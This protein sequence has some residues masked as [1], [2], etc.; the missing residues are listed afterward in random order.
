MPSLITAGVLA[1]LF[2]L[3]FWLASAPLFD[4]SLL[5]APIHAVGLSA[6]LCGIGVAV[7]LLSLSRHR[8]LQRLR[9]AHAEL[10]QYQF[11]ANSLTDMLSVMDCHY[12]Y[13]AVN[14]AYCRMTGSPR[15]GILGRT[16]SQMWGADTFGRYI[17]PHVKRCLDGETVS[18]SAWMGFQDGSQRYCEVTYRPLLS[19][20]GI[21][22]HIV[23]LTRDET[24]TKDAEMRAQTASA[25]LKALGENS[26]CSISVKGLDGRFLYANERWHAW[27]NPEGH[28][29][30]GKSAAALFEPSVAERMDRD[31]E[32]PRS[33]QYA[34]QE[35]VD[36]RFPDGSV[37]QL[38]RQCTVVRGEMQEPIALCSIVIDV[39][40]RARAEQE[41]RDS[42]EMVRALADAL[43][44][45]VSLK[46]PEG[47]YM[48]VNQCFEDW[49]GISRDEALGQ[50]TDDVLAEHEW[51]SIEATE[52]DVVRD[53]GTSTV[54]RDVRFGDGTNRYGRL[55]RFPVTNDRGQPIGEGAFFHDLTEM[56][57]VQAQLRIAVQAAETAARAKSTFLATMSHEIRTPL[58]AI[59]GMSHLALESGLDAHQRD[60]VAKIH[61]SAQGLLA[62][63][64]N[65][66]DVSKVEAG[67]MALELAQFALDDVLENVA[68][69][70]GTPAAE[71]RLEVIFDVG[72]SVPRALIGDA[73]RL[74]QVL[75]NLA[76]NAVKFTETGTVTV[77]IGRASKPAV[78]PTFNATGAVEPSLRETA[79][80]S[81][82]LFEVV[83][84][85]VGIAA[86]QQA[87]LF[88]PFSQADSSTTRRFGGT[89]LGLTIS[90]QIVRLM[91]GEIAVQSAPGAGSRFAF[92][93]DIP[94]ALDQAPPAPRDGTQ[95]L[96]LDG[97]A[98][99]AAAY[100]NLLTRAGYDICR[101]ATLAEFDA[102]L[103]VLSAGGQQ[104]GLV[105]ADAELHGAELVASAG[106]LAALDQKREPAVIFATEV[107]NLAE[108][109]RLTRAFARCGCLS[110]PLTGS[111]LEQGL[112]RID[113]NDAGPTSSDI[114]NGRDPA[115][116]DGILGAEVLVVE[117][118]HINA[119]VVV[120]LLDAAGVIATVAHDGPE[121]LGAL[122]G[123]NFELVLLD[124]ELPGFDG[125]EVVRRFG[126]ADRIPMVAMTAHDVD[127]V[128]TQCRAVGLREV[129]T[130]PL[131]PERLIEL[132]ITYIKP[133]E[134]TLS[135]QRRVFDRQAISA[136]LP[137]ALPG[138]AIDLGVRGLG[139]NQGLYIRLVNDLV[140]DPA[141][142]LATLQEA[143]ESEDEALITRCAHTLKGV[144]ATLGAHRL[145]E[146]AAR[147]EKLVPKTH[148][149]LRPVRITL[150]T[151]IAALRTSAAVLRNRAD[152]RTPD[153]SADVPR[154]DLPERHELLRRLRQLLR[155]GDAQTTQLLPQLR[156]LDWPEPLVGRVAQLA[157]E[158]EDFDFEEAHLTLDDLQADL[159]DIPDVVRPFPVK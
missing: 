131:D 95:A 43:P 120:E 75:T 117:D 8:R 16:V 22:S 42:R 154:S 96:I 126:R 142:P 78:K 158:I 44:H 110:K 59:L 2:L 9:A 156:A 159:A 26:L 58:N 77:R 15:E 113:P 88:T 45:M 140:F 30:L 39:T 108:A 24:A 86:E 40:E 7:M 146:L 83:D 94:A 56:R 134:R 25:W 115:Q 90:A 155:Q 13:V 80:N 33:G 36:F 19:D 100:E 21:P 41:L 14:D 112:R 157:R 121:A 84:T 70:V 73:L 18:Y 109:E 132:L 31:L 6:V 122:R 55:T 98:V 74:G 130:K 92:E 153:T 61:S 93:V 129:V 106:L 147:T 67:E 69:A 89:G 71:K 38:L 99:R 145:Q 150:E 135:K 148:E 103:S 79:A 12:R 64:N 47:R 144:A 17:E 60:Y 57:N 149:S 50:R 118:N 32:L 11:M 72:P 1:T 114:H 87:R 23:V 143:L 20:A 68:V 4:A 51:G 53:G 119:Q 91:G 136:R 125:L 128:D 105:L 46:D 85:G 137:Y 3:A 102:A 49:M 37:R 65:I 76:G 138:L 139:G 34:H 81:R 5:A 141:G 124:I 28:D 151:E 29:V 152:T 116:F 107:L 52:A 82:L 66:L 133:R 127:T 97:S 63:V 101:A 27:F 123:G 111:A 48:F 104:L 10:N 62:L 35:E 54:D